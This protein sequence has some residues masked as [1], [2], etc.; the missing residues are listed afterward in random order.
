MKWGCCMKSKTVYVVAAL[1]ITSM[2]AGCG[3]AVEQKVRSGKVNEVQIQEKSVDASKVNEKSPSKENQFV[4][5]E[6]VK[7]LAESKANNV[8]IYYPQIK[9]LKGQLM[10]DYMNQTLKKNTEKYVQGDTYKDVNIDYKIT[11]MD[12]NILS[13]LFKG[14]AKI[15]GG[16]EINIQ[17]S[18]NLDMN[19]SNPIVYE[20]YI[21]ADQKSGERVIAMLHQKAKAMGR[22]GNEFERTRIY[23]EGGNVVFFYMPTDDSATR[24]VELIVPALELEGLVNTTFG[25]SLSLCRKV[26]NCLPCILSLT[27]TE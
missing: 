2:L 6:V 8:T 19:T 15:S 7:K 27:V 26:S 12:N 13:V 21:K 10:M 24:F 16:K 3:A 9:G 5:Y 20:N 17:Q 23:F 22:M 14:T 4:G 25:E 1:V 11:K 18:I